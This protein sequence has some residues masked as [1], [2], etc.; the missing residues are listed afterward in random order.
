ML[1]LIFISIQKRMEVKIVGYNHAK[2]ERKFWIRWT[3]KKSMY[4]KAG[5][6]EEQINQI[7]EYERLEFNS[8]RS[9]FEHT[10]SFSETN[11]SLTLFYQENCLFSDWNNWMQLIPENAY[12]KLCQLPEEHLKAFT[13]HRLYGYTQQEVS[14]ILLK[15][16]ATISRWIGRIAEILKDMK[17]DA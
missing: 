12:R 4:M 16:Q 8:N 1:P 3:E 6:T 2:E 10:V 5:M 17:N 15:D 7:Y 11:H 13:L 14:S 9:F